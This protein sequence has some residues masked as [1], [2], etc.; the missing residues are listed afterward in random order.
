MILVLAALLGALV[1]FYYF[2]LRTPTQ[3]ANVTGIKWLFSIY[4]WGDS[5]DEM[6]SKP[7]GV[8]SDADGNIYV[9][10]PPRGLVVVFDRNG[11]YLRKI[12]GWGSNP[13]NLR[14][15][16]SVSVSDKFNRVYVAD[17]VRFRLVI[18]NKQGQFIKE[19]PVLS[20]VCVYAAPDDKVYLATFGPIVVYD[21]DGNQLKTYGRRG[22][23]PGEFDFPHGLAMDKKGYLYV[24]DTNNTRLQVL[25]KQ[26]KVVG[27]LGAPPSS[28]LETTREFG[29]PAGLAIDEKE[30]L[31]VVDSFDFSIKVYTK[32]GKFLG[33][34][35]TDESG[36]LEGQFKYADGIAYMGN[37][38]FAV[39]DTGNNRVQV[40]QITLPG[41]GGIVERLPWWLWLFLIPPLLYLASLFGRKKYYADDEFL[42]KITANQKLA[43]LAAVAPKVFVIKEL[44]EKYAD[45]EEEGLRA[46]EVLVERDYPEK[47]AEEIKENYKLD[48]IKTSSLAAARKRWYERVLFQRPIVFCEDETMRRAASDMKLRTMNYD[49]F[50]EA[51]E[52]VEE[53]EA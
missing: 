17:R 13:G 32:T 7:R 35:G 52:V 2:Y 6:L 41:E 47:V 18:Y 50:I 11:N 28:L 42:T 49:E 24:S 12:G 27:V 16:I 30:R 31:F 38:T 15:P 39:A 8:A 33:R 40:I 14:G 21:K 46:D 10:V 19:I 3:Q 48:D 44:Y 26:R 29:L 5:K 9:T 25:N 22:L 4:G 36:S 51:Y 45:Y 34:F 43:L 1:Y 23:L 20:P 53:E 37:R